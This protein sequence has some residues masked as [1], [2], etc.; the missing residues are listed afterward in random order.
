MVQYKLTTEKIFY[1]QKNVVQKMSANLDAELEK[2]V[3][4]IKDRVSREV[5]DT[6]FFRN[7]AENF[8]KNYKPDLFCKNIAL[9]VQRDE[10]RDGRAFLGVSALHPTMNKHVST[11]IMNGN[12]DKILEYITNSNFN[13]E[14][15]DT[16]LE[17]S[18][19]LEKAD[20]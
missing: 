6:G 9:F 2:I 3:N 5:P 20:L 16:V 1:N 12:R 8:D 15:K 7:F 14:F 4:R 11:Y 10:M 13:K 18:K 17:L 19:A